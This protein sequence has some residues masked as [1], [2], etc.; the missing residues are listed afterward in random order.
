MAWSSSSCCAMACFGTTE[1]PL[2]AADA[3]FT[4]EVYRTDTDSAVSELFALVESLDAI[5]ERE[6]RVRFTARDANWLFNVASCQSSREI[7]TA[8]SG[9]RLPAI[10]ADTVG[11]RLVGRAAGWHRAV[12]DYR[13]GRHARSTSPGSTGT[14]EER[15][16]STSSKSR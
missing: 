8:S 3:A 4:F 16:G 10:R 6:L 11:I 15:R 7:S 14:G 13:M 12:A 9:R 1:L 5:S 2:T